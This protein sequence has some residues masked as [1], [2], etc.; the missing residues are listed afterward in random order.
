MLDPQQIAKNF[1]LAEIQAKID[2][3]LTL[4]DQAAESSKYSL[5]TTQ[6][7]QSVESHDLDKLTSILNTWI[8]AKNILSGNTGAKLYG[9][10]YTRGDRLI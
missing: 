5:D 8:T 1:T 3:Y 10:D 6:G 2:I 9:A 7:R 4:I